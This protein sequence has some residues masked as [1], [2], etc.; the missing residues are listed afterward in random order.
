MMV[1]VGVRK[2]TVLMTIYIGRDS[3]GNEKV[4]QSDGHGGDNG[5]QRAM[6]VTGDDG[7]SASGYDYCMDGG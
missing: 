2:L 1:V 3:H 7:D 4:N 6:V 5:E